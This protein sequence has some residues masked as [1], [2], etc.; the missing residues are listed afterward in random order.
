MFDPIRASYTIRDELIRYLRTAFATQ[1]STMEDERADLLRETVALSQEPWLEP[2]P[3]YRRSGKRIQDVTADDVPTLSAQARDAFVGLCGSGLI[4]DY[5]LYSHQLEMLTRALRGENLVVTAGTGS[6]K[7]EAF[8]L[9]LFAYLVNESSA[10]PAPPEAAP[11]RDDWWVDEDWHNQCLHRDG[12]GRARRI[13]SH[14]VPQRSPEGREAAVRAL[15]VYPLNA[16]VE[17]QLTRLRRALDSD[18]SREW[19]RVNRLDNRFFFGRYNGN[20]PVPG[21][22]MTRTG[23][24]NGVKIDKLLWEL[25]REDEAAKVAAASA[26]ETGDDS[27][28]YFFPRLDGAEMRSRW[29]MQDSPPDILITNFSMLG[30]MLMRE[31]EDPIFAKTRDWL[32]HEG[33]VFH[34]II[35]ELHLYRGTAGTEVAY[36]LRLLLDRLGLTPDSPKLRI[37]ASS[38]SVDSGDEASTTF[39]EDFFGTAWR[40]DQIIAGEMVLSTPPTRD[41]LPREPF[42]ALAGAAEAGDEVQIDNAARAAAEALVPGIDGASGLAALKNAV[43]DERAEFTAW[44]ERGCDEGAGPQAVPLSE[45]GQR[46]FGG[47]ADDPETLLCSRGLL[48]S[49][50]TVDSGA[51]LTTL[52]FHL[53]FR[54]LE[55]L[56]GCSMPGCGCAVEIGRPTGRLFVENP[57]I[58]CGADGA[59]HRVLEQL[60]CEQCGTVM[61]GGSRH[62]LRDNA[63]WELLLTDP[64]IEGIPDRQAARFVERRRYR[65]YAVFWPSGRELHHQAA[66]AWNQPPH[67]GSP[68]EDRTRARWDQASLDVFTGQVVLERRAP[69]VPDGNWAPGYVFHLYQLVQ[70]EQQEQWLALPSICPNCGSDY[71]RR[72]IR[73]SP[74]RGFRTGFGRVSQL[75]SKELFRRLAGERD[76][77]LVVFSDSREDAASLA[78]SMERFH[79]FDLV[80]QV[81]YATLRSCVLDEPQLAEELQDHGNPVTERA[82]RFAE[83]NPESVRRI[84]QQV[85]SAMLAIPDGIPE[86]T[87]ATL[88]DLRTTAQAALQALR[89]R[90]RLR[91]VPLRFLFEGINGDSEDGAIISTL[92]SLGVNPA[93]NDVL[94]QEIEYDGR[95]HHWTTLFDFS[96]PDRCWRAG[97]SPAAIN[98]RENLFREKVKSELCTVMFRGLYLSFE[99]SGLGYPTLVVDR[100]RIEACAREAGIPADRLSKIGDA[101]VRV[102]G[103]L[104]RYPQPRTGT[105]DYPLEPWPDWRSVRARLKHYVHTVADRL[106]VSPRRLASE[107]RRLVTDDRHGRHP[108]FILDPRHLGVRISGPAD[109]VWRCTSCRRPHLHEGGYVC[110]NCLGRLPDDPTTNCAAL[111][112]HNYYASEA[113]RE[114]KPFRLHCEELS[115]QTDDQAGRQRLFRD[116]ILNVGEEDRELIPIVDAIDLLSVT[117]TMEVGIDIGNLSA[118]VLANMPPMRFNYQQRAGR[119]GRRGQAFAFV[120]T[121]C[122]GRSH[123][124]FYYRHPRRITTERPPVPFLS[125]RQTEIALRLIKKECLRRA[126]RNAGVRWWDGPDSPDTH[127]E[128]GKSEDW[129]EASPRGVAVADWLR[130]STEVA[131]VVAAVSFGVAGLDRDQLVHCV[132]DEL[133]GT[134]T[135]C[136]ANDE[137]VA[138]SLSERLAEGGVLPMFGMPSRVRELYQR[139]NPRR[140]TLQTVDRD[141]DIAVS[142]FAPGSQRTKD[143]RIYT[144]IGFTP[145]IL[146]TGAGLRSSGD[147]PFANPR[148]MAR[149]ER[150]HETH[151]YDDEPGALVC[152][153][154][155]ADPGEGF[156]KFRFVVPRAFR[157]SFGPGADA[158]EEQEILAS[159]GSSVAESDQE[160]CLPIPNTN[161]KL[162]LRTGGRVFRINDNRGELFTG[163]LGTASLNR[164]QYQLE[165]Q[166]IDERFQNN[167][168][169]V[170]FARAEEPASLAI[171]SPKTTDVLRLRPD[172]VPDGLTLDPLTPG[173]AVKGAYY[174]AAFVLRSCAA[175][176]LDIDPEELEVSNVR[177]VE[178]DPGQ[179]VGEIVIN[180]YL[181]NG[182][183]FTG[184]L[185]D[186][187]SQVLNDIDR[188]APGDGSVVGSLTAIEHSGCDSS[189]YDCLRQYRNMSYHGLLDWRLGLHFLRILWSDQHTAGLDGNF[190]LPELAGWLEHARALR[191]SFCGAFGVAPRNVGR[192]WGFDAAERTVILV[193]PLW[194]TSRPRGLLA[195]AIADLPQERQ[196][197]F[198]DTFNVLRR[199]SHAY[200]TLDV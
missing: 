133:I 19:F 136:S 184:W 115:A 177:S 139:V 175:D 127:G 123:D 97:L 57:P 23:R 5:Q 68:V 140:R 54:N 58:L 91:V 122:R 182:A 141:L 51:G 152:L 93:G 200:L 3:R 143:K 196:A 118:V 112:E 156:R 94:Y 34:L 60:Y 179:R 16:L 32:A 101:C 42:S 150:C 157:A 49:R 147:S 163:C 169:G 161:T 96:T 166:W 12:G 154:C 129:D 155:G 26:R 82:V 159:T 27:A 111:W 65:E 55:G 7:T 28:L 130:T 18:A 53:F 69:E 148:W 108:H 56:W 186:H 21:H 124:E 125:V 98:R 66:R 39:L 90:A 126:F 47:D 59:Q 79:Y 171:A 138:D 191:D 61:F 52:R 149:C 174:S 135:A 48:L 173:A 142:E 77:K 92:K 189:C 144:A 67:P 119:T 105:H 70:P 86:H 14:R 85:E 167:R 195:E 128:F 87:K 187:W 180:D 45:F 41:V 168:E 17:D 36:L 71:G 132:R 9:P 188:A 43:R 89:D 145:P 35:D 183:G 104:Y 181:P 172:V 162:D 81:A 50:G 44:C 160:P 80:R 193:H 198:L 84:R 46:I 13:R 120:L 10:W 38:A 72:L 6:G 75:L 88:E 15:I 33:S 76:P 63:G 40:S 114:E 11:H 24:P 170:V 25:Q 116:I 22:E 29:D 121:L 107:I 153:N 73:R 102:L 20:T 30:I 74:I 110:T 117:T 1:F 192:L 109:P 113:I 190:Q 78:N 99:S 134:I 100:E 8:L 106:G 146:Y 37:L 194:N 4:G 165:N 158:R 151:V 31:V 103:D 62:T 95:F 197:R 83:K 64:D 178:I 176:Q 185:A 137:L 199:P 164:N 2:L 131:D